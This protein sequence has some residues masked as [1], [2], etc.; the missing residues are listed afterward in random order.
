MTDWV[1]FEGRI[2]TLAWGRATYTI[3]RL[4]ARSRGSAF[5]RKAGRGEFGEQPCNLAFARADG[6]GVF[7][8]TGQSL[9]TQIACAPESGSRCAA[10]A[11]DERR[12]HAAGR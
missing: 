2:E 11:P 3:L 9:M 4:P 7:L 6:G 10:P 5:R 8:W 12:G 1:T